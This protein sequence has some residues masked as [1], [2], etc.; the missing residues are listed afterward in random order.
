L[1]AAGIRIQRKAA[2]WLALRQARSFSRREE[3]DFAQWMARDPRHAVIFAEVES[4]WQTFDRLAAYPHSPQTAVDPDLLISKPVRSRRRARWRPI[5]LA[6]AAAIA[7]SGIAWL[8]P[9]L[10][11]NATAPTLAARS[12]DGRSMRLPDGSTVELNVGSLVTEHFTSTQRRLRLVRGEAHFSVTKDPT[13]EF[14]VEADGVAIRAVGTAFNVRLQRENVEVLV[15]EGIVRIAPPAVPTL[16]LLASSAG[17]SRPPDTDTSAT[18]SAGQRAVVSGEASAT[19]VPPR[20][21]TLTAADID[22]ELAWQTSSLNFDATPLSEAVRQLN[23]NSARQTGAPRLTIRDADVG[24]ILISGRVQ[25]N[26]V[27]SFVE[28]L[29][30]SFGVV[31]ERHADGEILLRRSPPAEPTAK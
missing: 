11:Q 5:V 15:T 22:R 12:N 16:Q 29:E 28:A 9:S 2:E 24:A 17:S 25:T 10:V 19:P 4:S 31:A 21:E 27:E 8:G 3:E 13:R 18:V 20:I 6:A 7:V 23:R 14:I 1:D 26:K 30:T